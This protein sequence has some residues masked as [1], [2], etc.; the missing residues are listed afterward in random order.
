M[1]SLERLIKALGRLPGIGWRSAERMALR[2]VM[3][4][5]K[6]VPELIAAL[7]DARASLRCCSKCG[8]ITRV[9]KDPCRLCTDPSRD[10]SVLCV[11]EGPSDISLV[12]RT[13]GYRGRY[14]ALMGKISPMNQ[15]G[16]EDIRVEALIRR[17]R[18]E[19]FKE[20]I[21][22]LNSDVE[23]D[24]T[25]SYLRD[26]LSRLKVRVTRLALGIPAGSGLAYSDSVTLSRAIEGRTEM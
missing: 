22:A 20:I 19:G 6:L 26:V 9:D 2:L 15:K 5:E 16:I 10:D 25:A 3:E 23:S 21:L 18:E 1:D 7:E 4:S 14:H 17:V 11:V 8:N 13:G 12:E 24:A